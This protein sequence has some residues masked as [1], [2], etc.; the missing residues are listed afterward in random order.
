MTW[1]PGVV[2]ERRLVKIREIIQTFGDSKL[3]RKSTPAGFP[4]HAWLMY[5]MG[6]NLV[7]YLTQMALGRRRYFQTV[8]P[9]AQRLSMDHES[10]TIASMAC[11][12]DIERTLQPIL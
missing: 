8:I 9:F 7:N 10:C 1:T 3:Q 6:Q 5:Y 12:Q 2:A 11:D 4:F